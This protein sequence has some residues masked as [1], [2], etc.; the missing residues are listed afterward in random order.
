MME[1]INQEEQMDLITDELLVS[2]VKLNSMGYRRSFAYQNYIKGLVV[3][4]GHFD[5]ILNVLVF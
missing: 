1:G 2:I 5:F 3:T 4:G